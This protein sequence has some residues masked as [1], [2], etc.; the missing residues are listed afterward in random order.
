MSLRKQGSAL[1]VAVILSDIFVRT[2]KSS[3]IFYLIPPIASP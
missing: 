3:E 2:K 1:V